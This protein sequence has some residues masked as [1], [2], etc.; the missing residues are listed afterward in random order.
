MQPEK[1]ILLAC[2]AWNQAEEDSAAVQN[3]IHQ[4]IDWA[5]LLR[6]AERH[7]LIPLMYYGLKPHRSELPAE[8]L[9]QLQIAY[10]DN[11][12]RALLWSEE[13]IHLFEILNKDKIQAL[14]YKGPALSTF[15]YGDVGYR[16][17]S[18][19]DIL[20]RADDFHRVKELLVARRY[21]P[22]HEVSE[23]MESTYL[24]S[25]Y[26][27]NFRNEQ[28]K[29]RLEVHWNVGPKYLSLQFD[30]KCFWEAPTD[31]FINGARIPTLSI[32]NVISTLCIHGTKHGW[33]RLSLV[34][35][36]GNLLRQKRDVDWN[37][38]LRRA[39]LGEYS[40]SVF[41]GL[42]LSKHMMGAPLPERVDRLIKEDDQVEPLAN[43][44]IERLRNSTYHPASDARRWLFLLR[45]PRNWRYRLRALWGYLLARN[46]DSW[47][48][49]RARVLDPVNRLVRAGTRLLLR[50]HCSC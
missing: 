1:E 12:V 26:E 43:E 27:F 21:V 10:R 7:A 20:I 29:M 19:L 9:Q 25:E 5:I 3:L 48:S 24:K 11:L 49:P 15:I 39:C 23:E 35:D 6:A 38:I 8:F 32:E 40:R 4:Q 28:K 34:A 46:P 37:L 17:F 50:S 47:N 42:I 44:C 2:L 22:E 30:S 14:A 16:Q 41:L 13:L 33:D 18:D 31:V 36:L 45:I